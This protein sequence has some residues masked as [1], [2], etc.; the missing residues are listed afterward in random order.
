MKHAG[1]CLCGAVRFEVDGDFDGFFLCH[2][3]RCRKGAGSAHASNLFSSSAK[4]TWL[5]GEEKVRRYDVEGTRHQRAF[6]SEC[7]SAAPRVH[8]LG[9]VVVPAGSLDTPLDVRPTAHICC[10]SRATWDAD[11]ES[12]PK[13]DGLPWQ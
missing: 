6:C 2:C 4:L 9:G 8:P 10:A 5:S 13:F 7:G 12:V 1:S 3:S 11:L